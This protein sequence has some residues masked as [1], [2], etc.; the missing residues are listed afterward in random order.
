MR[1]RFEYLADLASELAVVACVPGTIAVVALLGSSGRV[2]PFVGVD[3]PSHAAACSVCRAQQAQ[4][5]CVT[6]KEGVDRR[7]APVDSGTDK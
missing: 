1:L 6:P 7:D 5:L 2:E 3:D 4:V